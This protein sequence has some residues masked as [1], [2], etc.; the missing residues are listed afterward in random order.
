M[1][2][3]HV[4]GLR[5]LLNFRTRQNRARSGRRRRLFNRCRDASFLLLERRLQGRRDQRQLRLLQEVEEKRLEVAGLNILTARRKAQRIAKAVMVTAVQWR[6]EHGFVD[7]NE[8]TSGT[9]GPS[10]LERLS[11]AASQPEPVLEPHEKQ[12]NALFRRIDSWTAV[13]LGRGLRFLLASGLLAGFALWLDAKGIVTAGQVREQAVELNRV[14]R[15]A[16]LASDPSLL[17]ELTWNLAVDWRQLDQPLGIDRLPAGPWTEIHG[18]NLGSA[19]LILLFSTLSRR[20]VT[21]LM[22]LLGA[23]LALFGG[24]WGAS[25]PAIFGALDQH[26]QALVL[27]IFLFIVGVV[28]PRKKP[29]T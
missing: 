7:T 29:R 14:A 8:S 17:R 16:I 13:L 2:F 25:I 10:L 24:R 1:L 18:S 20:K 4:L 27:G 23:V 11:A 26:A 19:G 12:P 15:R 22:A 28:L 21:A 6:E 5:A 9:H 3:E